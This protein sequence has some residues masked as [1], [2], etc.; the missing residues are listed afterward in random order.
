MTII[1]ISTRRVSFDH[2][3]QL[4]PSKLVFVHRAQVKF[5]FPGK[6]RVNE[7]ASQCLRDVFFSK[8]TN[9]FAKMTNLLRG[10]ECRSKLSLL[11]TFSSTNFTFFKE[12]M[13]QVTTGGLDFVI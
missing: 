2:G 1:R 4:V 8:K 6:G 13:P 11:T 7:I 5:L 3:V 12:P 10:K 9:L